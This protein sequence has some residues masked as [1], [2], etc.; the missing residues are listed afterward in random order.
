MRG[1]MRRL[2][3]LHNK[4]VWPS[5][6]APRTDLAPTVP[7]AP[8]ARLSTTTAWPR[9]ADILSDISRAISSGGRHDQ[10]D[11]SIRI[12]L[13]GLQRQQLGN[14]RQ[15]N[16]SRLHRAFPLGRADQ[17]PVSPLVYRF[18]NQISRRIG[19]G[20]GGLLAPFGN[21]IVTP[22]PIGVAVDAAV[23]GGD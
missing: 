17:C 22:D 2:L 7:P 10:L 19:G 5:G 14:D 15:Q 23:A 9:S 3:V 1:A 16:R 13:C 20:N 4:I 11:R 12:G 8:P 6:S 18:G 21:R